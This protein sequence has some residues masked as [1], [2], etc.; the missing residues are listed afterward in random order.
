MRFLKT[1]IAR[2]AISIRVQFNAEFPRQ[3][4]NF[5]IQS[6]YTYSA[7]L[8]KRVKF[9]HPILLIASVSF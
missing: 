7:V 8:T 6:T 4:M 9:A 3:V 5:P 2:I 1:D